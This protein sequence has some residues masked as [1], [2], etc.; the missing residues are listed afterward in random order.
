MKEKQSSE[1]LLDAKVEAAFQQV[2]KTVIK[3]AKETNTAV[4]VWEDGCVKE[5]LSTQFGSEAS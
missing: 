4:I 2:V 3:R 5:V 1:D